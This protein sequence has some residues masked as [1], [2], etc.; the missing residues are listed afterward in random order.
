MGKPSRVKRMEIKAKRAPVTV[1]TPAPSENSRRAVRDIFKEARSNRTHGGG[2][3]GGHIPS[4][5]HIGGASERFTGNCYGERNPRPGLCIEGTE[6]YDNPGPGANRPLDRYRAPSLKVVCDPV[7]PPVEPDY[8]RRGKGAP[9]VKAP[10][11]TV[12]AD[13][14]RR[15]TYARLGDYAPDAAPALL[16][17]PPVARPSGPAPRTH[18]QEVGILWYGRIVPLRDDVRVFA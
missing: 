18:S 11:E 4:A 3:G 14:A 13:I 16:P 1:E 9:A 8:G 17:L 5:R 6:R 15:N 10:I 12:D 7:R 2:S